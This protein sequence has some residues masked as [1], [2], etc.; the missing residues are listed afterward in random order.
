VP[1]IEGEDLPD[2][3]AA[4]G[5]PRAGDEDHSAGDVPG[6]LVKVQPDGFAVEEVFHLHV[7]DAG[8]G[9]LAREDFPYSGDDPRRYFG[10]PG[11]FEDGPDGVAHDGGD[12]DE[13]FVHRLAPGDGGEAFHRTEDGVA[14]EG[15]VLL[16]GIIVEEAHGDEAGLG[17]AEHLPDD[18]G[19]GVPGADDEDPLVLPTAFPADVPFEE[20]ADQEAGGPPGNKKQHAVDEGDAAGDAVVGREEEGRRGGEK[21]EGGDG[22]AEAGKVPDADAPPGL[23]EEAEAED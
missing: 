11:R 6:D 8:D 20:D 4:D 12:G 13:D 18:H 23:P 22:L 14:H 9:D 2:D 3:L 5:S 21:G 19:A 17:V 15:G 1:G 7:P 10:L 16:G